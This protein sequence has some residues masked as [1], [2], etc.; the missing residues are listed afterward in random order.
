MATDLYEF[1]KIALNEGCGWVIPS[2]NAE[3]LAEMVLEVA[4]NKEDILLK[5]ETVKAL[6]KRKYT[7]ENMEEKILKL[8][9]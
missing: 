8:Y 1:R 5:K 7:W 3:K 9:S 2:K 4:K 6:F